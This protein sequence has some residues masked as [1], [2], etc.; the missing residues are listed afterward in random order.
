MEG[1]QGPD[2]LVQIWISGIAHGLVSVW[3]LFDNFGTEVPRRR[4]LELREFPGFQMPAPAD[5]SFHNSRI[6]VYNS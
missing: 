3:G 2:V 1:I 6:S 5:C 4:L